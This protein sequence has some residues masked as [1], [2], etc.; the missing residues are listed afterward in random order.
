MTI[1][2]VEADI[3]NRAMATSLLKGG[4]PRRI[5]GDR[6]DGCARR[7]RSGTES[8]AFGAKIAGNGPNSPL[9]QWIE[10]PSA[11]VLNWK[12]AK[13]PML[14]RTRF[15]SKVGRHSCLPSENT[16]HTTA[17]FQK[18]HAGLDIVVENN[19]Y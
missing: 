18:I 8:P 1:G 11:T 7:S 3:I 15:A 14:S 16:R 10:P 6:R 17:F 13:M 12:I 9:S 5:V 2:K 4:E 19:V